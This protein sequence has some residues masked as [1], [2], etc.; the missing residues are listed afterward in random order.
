MNLRRWLILGSLLLVGTGCP[1][2]WMRGGTNDRAMHKDT[3]D[4]VS[5]PSDDEEEENPCPEDKVASWK[6]EPPPCHWVCE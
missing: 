5:D 2:D 3:R 6:C 4:L 1:H